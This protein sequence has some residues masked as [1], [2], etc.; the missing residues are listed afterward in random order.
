M[1]ELG[2]WEFL[3]NCNKRGDSDSFSVL[4]IFFRLMTFK[5]ILVTYLFYSEGQFITKWFIGLVFIKAEN[6]NIDLTY[7][8]QS[9]TDTGKHLVEL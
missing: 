2:I 5:I 9:F 7:D 8:I 3:I 1:K 4:D 6:V